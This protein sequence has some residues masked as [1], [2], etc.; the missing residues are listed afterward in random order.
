MSELRPCPFCGGVVCLC[1]AN[2]GASFSVWCSDCG[3]VNGGAYPS[4]ERAAEAW[5]HRPLEDEL[6][7]AL[8]ELVRLKDLKETDPAAHDAGKEDAWAAARA[9]VRRLEVE[10]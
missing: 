9:A 10:S 1:T 2:R 3:W 5:N 4:R 8:K 7:A 6:A